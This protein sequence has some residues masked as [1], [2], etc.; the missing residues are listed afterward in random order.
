MIF[1]QTDVSIQLL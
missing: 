1:S